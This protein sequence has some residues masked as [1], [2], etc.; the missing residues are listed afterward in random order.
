MKTGEV[1]TFRQWKHGEPIPDGWEIV[2][3]PE[4]YGHHGNH[5][6][7]IAKTVE[8]AAKLKRGKP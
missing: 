6:V 1:R 7:L 2:R 3:H 8:P 4:D 5:A